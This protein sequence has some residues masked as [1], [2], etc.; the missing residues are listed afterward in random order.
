VV[1]VAG[2]FTGGVVAGEHASD[3]LS[4]T[5]T[6]HR[7]QVSADRQG[8]PVGEIRIF[9]DGGSAPGHDDYIVAGSETVAEGS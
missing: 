5:G 6:S 8:A 4:Q 7:A 2:V 3:G 1:I 9:P